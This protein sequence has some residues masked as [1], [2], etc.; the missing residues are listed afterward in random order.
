VKPLHERLHRCQYCGMASLRHIRVICVPGMSS[1]DIYICHSRKACEK[2]QR[3]QGV[4]LNRYAP[5]PR[6]RRYRLGSY[7]PSRVWG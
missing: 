2:R 1:A 4:Y 7:Y 5:N 6:G 3:A